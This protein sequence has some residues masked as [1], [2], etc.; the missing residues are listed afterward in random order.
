MAVVPAFCFSP[1]AD[2]QSFFHE[3]SHMLWM[4]G[5]LGIFFFSLEYNTTGI[6]L[7][8]N[9]PEKCLAGLLHIMGKKEHAYLY[10]RIIFLLAKDTQ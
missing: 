5:C 7:G 4:A 3:V 9:I 10:K 2:G 8:I 1:V 6:R